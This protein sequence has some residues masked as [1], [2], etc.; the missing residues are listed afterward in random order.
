MVVSAASIWE[1]ATKAALETLRL[2]TDGILAEL[3]ELGFE[4]LPVTARHAWTVG[5]LPSHHRDLVDRTRV[6]QAQLEG[7]TIVT[8]DPAIA[9]YRIAVLPAS[10][11]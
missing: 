6:A 8:R 3:E 7:P 9:R 1:I 10:M 2:S 4:L 11:D 5:G